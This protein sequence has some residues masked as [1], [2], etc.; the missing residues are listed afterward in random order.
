MENVIIVSLSHD[1]VTDNSGFRL[2]TNIAHQNHNCK[3]KNG[4]VRFGSETRFL[5]L[6]AFR[7]A[8][9]CSY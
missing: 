1:E 4:F 5:I 8:V 9:T 3:E 7:T 2:I 6:P